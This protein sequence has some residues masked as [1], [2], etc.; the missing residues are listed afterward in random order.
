MSWAVSSAQLEP[1]ARELHR[2]VVMKPCGIAQNRRLLV[3]SLFADALFN[4]CCVLA[5]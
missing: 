2:D 4:Y 1:N 3:R 5:G